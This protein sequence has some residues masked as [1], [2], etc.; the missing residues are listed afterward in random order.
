MLCP[1]RGRHLSLMETKAFI[2]RWKAHWPILAGLFVV[3]MAIF[4]TIIITPALF[5]DIRTHAWIAVSGGY[6]P[7]PLYYLTIDLFS[8]F[9]D[10][11]QMLCA[12]SAPVLSIAVVAT[13]MLTAES[14]QRVGRNASFI[15]SDRRAIWWGIAL[16]FVFAVPLAWFEIPQFYLGYFTPNVWHNSTVIF[17][18]PFAVWSFTLGLEVLAKAN[19]KKTIW[20]TLALALTL[21]AKPSFFFVFAPTYG[22]FLLIKRRHIVHYLPLVVGTLI[23]AIQFYL[24]FE[25]ASSNTFMEDRKSSMIIDFL[26]CWSYFLSGRTDLIGWT[27]LGSF[28]FPLGNLLLKKRSPGMSIPVTFSW[29][30]VVGGVLMFALFQETGERM[31][32]GNFLWQAIVATYFLFLVSLLD[33]LASPSKHK[34]ITPLLYGLFGLHLLS[35]ILFLIKYAITKNPF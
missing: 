11:Y 14:L 13:V 30:M 28:L 1:K 3:C 21:L 18:M 29:I 8:G 12:A 22:L 27:L 25:A 24:I 6:P 15:I 35:G 19:R 33:L 5:S 2:A 10:H 17:L 9:T 16:N 20:L 32:H 26:D 23:L 34:W 31:H 4:S 7:Y